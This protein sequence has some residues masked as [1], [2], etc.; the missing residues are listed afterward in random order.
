MR[1]ALSFAAAWAVRWGLLLFQNIYVSTYVDNI[2]VFL[3]KP[4]CRWRAQL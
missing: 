3:A 4:G 2:E 1:R